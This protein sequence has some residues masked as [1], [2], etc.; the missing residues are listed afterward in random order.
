MSVGGI[1]RCENNC[2]GRRRLLGPSRLVGHD[3]VGPGEMACASGQLEI[4]QST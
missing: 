2:K 1:H 3:D 4:D